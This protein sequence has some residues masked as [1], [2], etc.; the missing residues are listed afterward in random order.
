LTG[1][2]HAD[3]GRRWLA[4]AACMVIAFTLGTRLQHW[5]LAQNIPPDG[6]AETEQ[7]G[8]SQQLLANHRQPDIWNGESGVPADI[9]SLLNR[10]GL[11][12]SRQKG[13]VGAFSAD[14][15]RVLVPYEDV[16]IVPARHAA[17]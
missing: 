9:E 6:M 1:A 10:L 13:L 14:G 2:D 8:D 7:P 16:Q 15:N 12:V 3:H 5:P 4:T 11:E 17:Q